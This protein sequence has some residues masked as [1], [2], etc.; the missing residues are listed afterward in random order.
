MIL[1]I[2]QELSSFPK[3]DTNKSFLNFCLFYIP[4]ILEA[5]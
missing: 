5:L 1:R 3:Y 4:L 2:S